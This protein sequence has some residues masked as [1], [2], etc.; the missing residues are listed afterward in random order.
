MSQPK[1]FYQWSEALAQQMH[2]LSRPQALV[3][4][5]F[6]LGVAL[7]KCCTLSVV[8]ESLVFLG[9]PD[10]VERRLQRF[11]ANPNLCWQQ[12]AQALAAWVLASLSSH[13]VLVLLVDETSLKERLKVMAV[14]LAYRN[15]ALPLAWWCYRQTAWPMGQV[16]L[17]TTLLKWVAKGVPK[18]SVVLV[19]ADRGIANSPKLLAAI[20]ALGFYYLVRV[21]WQVRLR[22]A[23]AGVVPFG[24]L[25]A[26]RGQRW[27]GR[28]EA[29]KKAGWLPCFAVGQWRAGY[30]EPW[31]L[32]TNYPPAQG[33]W[34]GLRMWKE[35]A[36]RDFKSSGWQ[37]QKSHVWQPEHANRLWLVLAL[38]YVWVLS[39]GTLVV[40]SKAWLR[41]LSRGKG[42]RH[43]VF[44]LGLR[45]LKRWL[46]LGR[47]LFYALV[48]MPHLPICPKSVV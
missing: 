27:R 43:S 14:S 46:A 9:K 25:V 28:V 15:R 2:H 19:E 38:A 3:L 21:G 7:A 45:W 30:K 47:P 40:R 29:F 44:Q 18:G 31:L 11:L 4:A 22:L 42:Q 34:Y 36:F 5:A 24:R 37:W 32:L 6:S 10:S 13:K 8:A 35:L 23:E 16:E 1:V 12:S 20:E 33:T 41:E 17:I 48:L 26:K 39:L